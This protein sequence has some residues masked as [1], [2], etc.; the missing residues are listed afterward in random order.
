MERSSAV[1]PVP[2][3]VLA[4]MAHP[5]DPE[6]S[7]AGTIALWTRAGAAVA[8]VILTDG[9]KGSSDRTMTAERLTALREAEQRAAATS[10]GVA[11]VTFLGYPDGALVP[12]IDLRHTLARQIRRHRPD[13][14][15]THDPSAYYFD[16]YINHP[17]H[18]AAG[19]AT[20]EAVFPTARD[21][22]NAP[23]L[24]ADEGLEPH[25]VRE[26][27]LTGTREPD[28]WIDIAPTFD[29]KLAALR[30]HASQIRE[31]HALESRL[32]E[33]AA[34]L[35]EGHGMTLAEAFKRIVLP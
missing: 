19:Q 33:R 2:E 25:A 12:D 20:L 1:A 16:R 3:R 29:L 7:S 18:R 15:L 13:L 35:A 22:L 14:V 27:W 10:L 9:S 28:T 30:Q 24:L 5:D 26:V 17:D 23:H 11:Q 31:P 21:W 34:S 4:V 8:Y 6:F 32:R